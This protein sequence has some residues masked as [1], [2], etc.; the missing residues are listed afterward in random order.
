MLF[1]LFLC[2]GVTDSLN[3]LIYM[4]KQTLF[5]L[6]IVFL[7]SQCNKE[8]EIRL[9]NMEIPTITGIHLRDGDGYSRG[10][11]GDPNTQLIGTSCDSQNKL[12]GISESE[13]TFEITAYPNP[14]KN[15]LYM[16]IQSNTQKKIWLVKANF[17]GTIPS[18]FQLGTNSF[19]AGGA[20]LF[21]TE[22]IDNSISINT[23]NLPTGYYR[24]YVETCDNLLWD[25]ILVIK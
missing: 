16:Y 8:P 15:N 6:F 17:E 21:S 1:F 18:N 23:T 10:V 5:L 12:G 19:E 11:I 25:N 9:S 14:C 13:T 2:K 22:T 20:P 24:I 7:T 3:L 4:K